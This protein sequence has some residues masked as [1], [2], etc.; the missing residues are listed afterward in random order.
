MFLT[1]FPSI[2][3]IISPP[4]VTGNPII[5]ICVSPQ[6]IPAFSAGLPVATVTTRSPLG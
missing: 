5:R 4:N 6:R 1:C 3:I 2:F